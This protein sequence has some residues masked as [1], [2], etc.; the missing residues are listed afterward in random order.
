MKDY[1][2]ELIA[3]WQ[4]VRPDID[5]TAVAVVSR[6]LRASQAIQL[7]LD[8]VIGTAAALSHKGD[9]DTLTALRRAGRGHS[10]S[11][12]TLA[13]VG[14]L[15]S[16]GM[17]NR[18][19]RLENSGLITRSPDPDDRRGVLVSLTSA[20]EE[21]ADEAFAAS[22]DEQ[23]KLLNALSA[24]EQ[25]AIAGALRVLLHSL[26]DLPLGILSD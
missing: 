26:G 11:P 18:L 17:T 1:V 25:K 5:T 3:S 15:T 12:K 9:L 19:D 22:L 4:T 23:R 10:L 2:D 14:Q 16:G 21:L 8:A 24:G 20:G 6:I 7:H 13:R